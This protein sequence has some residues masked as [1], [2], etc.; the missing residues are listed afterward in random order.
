MEVQFTSDQQAKL[1]RLATEQGRAVEALVLEAVDRLFSY[2]EW[3]AF[4][5]EKGLAAADQGEL[6]AHD[7]VRKMIECRYPA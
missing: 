2:D 6:V 7:A 4:E 3:F 1:S 5:V